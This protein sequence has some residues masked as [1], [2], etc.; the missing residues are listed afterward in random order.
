MGTNKLSYEDWLKKNEV[1]DPDHPEHFYDYKAAYKAGETKDKDGHWPSKFKHDLH[2]NRYI[3]QDDG[4]FLDTK[5]MKSAT[6]EDV[7]IQKYKRDEYLEEWDNV[8]RDK[9][10]RII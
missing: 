6:R 7:I 5:Y 8:T 1:N 9:A 4:S 10:A 3:E 2:P